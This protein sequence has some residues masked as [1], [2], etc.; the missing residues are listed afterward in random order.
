MYTYMYILKCICIFKYIH[1]YV[2]TYMYS[3]TSIIILI[4]NAGDESSVLKCIDHLQD[5]VRLGNILVCLS[6]L[7][8][9]VFCAPFEKRFG[10]VQVCD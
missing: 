7:E 9:N 6:K 2:Y 5:A 10:W 1:I 4:F 8:K 3:F